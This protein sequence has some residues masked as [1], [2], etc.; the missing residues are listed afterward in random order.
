[1]EPRGGNQEPGGVLR[2]AL[3]QF[4]P[5]TQPTRL[6]YNSWR[7][8][9]SG[10]HRPNGILIAYGPRIRSGQDA[11]EADLWDVAP[12]ILYMMGLPIPK[13]MDGKLLRQVSAEQL[14]EQRPPEYADLKGIDLPQPETR[15]SDEDE[16]LL[17]ERLRGLGYIE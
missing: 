17:K 4:A 14:L 16:E 8:I 5:S 11:V 3:H 10:G 12:T 1:M 9:I 13:D 2:E 15:P 7:E 6:D